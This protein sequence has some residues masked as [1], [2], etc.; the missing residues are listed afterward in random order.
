MSNMNVASWSTLA[1]VLSLVGAHGA[2]AGPLRYDD[3]FATGN[4]GIWDPQ[5]E[6]VG[7]GEILSLGFNF[8]FFGDTATSL[9]VNNFGTVDLLNIGGLLL[10][11]ITIAD[12]EANPNPG[13]TFYGRA[14]GGNPLPA[15]DGDPVTAGFRVQW[16]F[17]NSLQAQLALFALGSGGSLIEFNYLLEG[18][19]GLDLSDDPPALGVVTAGGIER[20]NLLSYLQAS[21]PGCLETFGRGTLQA[22]VDAPTDGCTSYFFGGATTVA[23]PPP[24]DTTNGGPAFD[25]TNADEAE[26]LADYR[27]LSRYA[28]TTDPTPV[29]EPTTLALL[30]AGFAAL[31]ASR[32]KRQDN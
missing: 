16:T 28:A 13:L 23:L 25:G 3:G 12:L 11:S 17:T 29:P 9:Q 4:S 31:A 14:A 30:M 22:A 6:D 15:L 21:Q 24:F 7:F 1:V 19:T 5:Q 8:D 10:G 32:R 2:H 18:A 26:A 20:F 27:Y